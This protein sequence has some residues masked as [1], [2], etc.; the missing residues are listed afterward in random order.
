M[1][2]MILLVGAVAV[3]AGAVV[4]ASSAGR[5]LREGRLSGGWSPTRD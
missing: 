5:G 3:V 2:R 4:A 1:R